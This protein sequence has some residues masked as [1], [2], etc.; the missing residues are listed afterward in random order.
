MSVTRSTRSPLRLIMNVAGRAPTLKSTRVLADA[1]AKTLVDFNVGALPAT[2]IINRNG[3]L[4][5]R[6]T[7]MSKLSSAVARYL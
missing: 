5:E 6:V 3:D 2:F 7:D 4:V 1:S